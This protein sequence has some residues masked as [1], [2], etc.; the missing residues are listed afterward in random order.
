MTKRKNLNSLEFGL[1]FS[2]FSEI[3]NNNKVHKNTV[4][5]ENIPKVKKLVFKVYL[6]R[7]SAMIYIPIFRNVVTK[8][9]IYIL[10]LI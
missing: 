2:N 1:L 6:S 9:S 5:I 7:F 3:K 8:D 10:F 4:S